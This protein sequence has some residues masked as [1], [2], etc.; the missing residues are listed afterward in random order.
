V[1]GSLLPSV[2]A[3]SRKVGVGLGTSLLKRELSEIGVTISIV[4]DALSAAD[5]NE[6]AIISAEVVGS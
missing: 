6:L 1:E 4:C 2:V 5:K 3:D